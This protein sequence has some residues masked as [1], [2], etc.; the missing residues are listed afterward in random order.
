ML[1]VIKQ[2]KAC[3]LIKQFENYFAQ[4]KTIANIEWI[5]ILWS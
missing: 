4:L 5:K 2:L 3:Y 1:C